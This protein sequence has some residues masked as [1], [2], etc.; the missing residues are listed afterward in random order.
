VI[1]FGPKVSARAIHVGGQ[2]GN[3]KSPHFSDQAQRWTTGDF[4]TVYFWPEQLRGHT[5]RAYHPGQ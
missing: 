2:S 5:A 4:R 1:D 3:P